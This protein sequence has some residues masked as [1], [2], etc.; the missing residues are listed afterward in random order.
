MREVTYSTSLSDAEWAFIE[1]MLVKCSKRGRPREV[2]LRAIVDAIFYM[3]RCGMPWRFLPAEFPHWKTVYR[4]FA[5]WRRDGRSEAVDAAL[6]ERLR[7]RLGRAPTPSAAIIDSQSVKT[8][9]C[10]GPRG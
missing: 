10:G 5:A 1:P 9:E 2:S 3:L 7:T 8:T 6:R 4:Y